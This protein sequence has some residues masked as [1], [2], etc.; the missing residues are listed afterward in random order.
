MPRTVDVCVCGCTGGV[1]VIM[2][3]VGGDYL[4]AGW[5]NTISLPSTCFYIMSDV[6]NN[7]CDVDV[8]VNGDDNGDDIS[9]SSLGIRSLNW[10]G[11]AVVIGFAS[12]A[13][14]KIPANILL[15]KNVE[16]SGLYWGASAIHNPALFMQSSK[17][18]I[19]MWVE[20]KVKPHV[21]HRVPLAEAND[22]LDIIKA[23]KST[24]KVLLV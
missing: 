17:E 12:G 14:P 22:A 1:D 6:D 18:V 19:S 23:R 13:I 21:S 8:D 3:A 15:V 7:V 11:R 24:G 16:V 2:D 9:Y 20:G 5:L 4:E 10:D